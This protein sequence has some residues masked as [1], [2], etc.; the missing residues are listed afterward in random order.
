MIE[1]EAKERWC[2][3]PRDSEVGGNRLPLAKP[4]P[5]CMCLASR[6]MAWRPYALVED[7]GYCGLV[8]NLPVPV[9]RRGVG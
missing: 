7:G 8:P 3:F 4:D 2:P 6:C 5:E 9:E 1:A